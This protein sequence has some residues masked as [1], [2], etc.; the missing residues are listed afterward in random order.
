[1]ST[2]QRTEPRKGSR[3]NVRNNV[4]SQSEREKEEKREAGRRNRIP[5]IVLHRGNSQGAG[6]GHGARR[7][8]FMQY[9][10]VSGAI[11]NRDK[12]VFPIRTAALLLYR[13]ESSDRDRFSGI[14]SS[15]LTGYGSGQH[16]SDREVYGD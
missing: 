5:R 14:A 4:A 2:C 15:A 10:K 13:R 16:A 8:S 6:V 1:M 11:Y 7:E 3:D 9:T 12:H